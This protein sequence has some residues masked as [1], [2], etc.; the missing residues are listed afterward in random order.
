MPTFEKHRASQR[1]TTVYCLLKL[2]YISEKSHRI[3]ISSYGPNYHWTPD[4]NQSDASFSHV[5]YWGNVGWAWFWVET[6][7]SVKSE[8]IPP[9][10]DY[11]RVDCE[12]PRI[13]AG[14]DPELYPRGRL[15]R[16]P[17]STPPS[18][19]LPPFIVIIWSVF[20][21]QNL[22]P[23]LSEYTPFSTTICDPPRIYPSLPEYT[24]FSTNVCATLP[25][26]NH[27]PPPEYIP[28]STTIILCGPSRIYPSPESTPLFNQFMCATTTICDPP[29]IHPSPQ[30]IPLFQQLYATFPES[31]PPSQNIGLPPPLFNKCICATLPESTPPSKNIPPR[32]FN[33]YMRPS[34]NLPLL[35]R[36][37]HLFNKCMCD[38]HRIYPPSQ[39]IPPFSTTTCGCP[40]IYPSLPEYTPFST[41][42]ILCDPPRI[43]PSLPEST[44]LFNQFMC[45]T[46]PVCDVRFPCLWRRSLYPLSLQVGLDTPLHDNGKNDDYTTLYKC[47]RAKRLLDIR[48]TITPSFEL[49]QARTNDIELENKKQ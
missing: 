13:Y 33:N 45:A 37:Y 44:H 26:Q 39:N 20:G 10:P 21:S 5:T 12:R 23:S 34:H 43:Y 32:L 41:T 16:L 7:T 35:P 18:Q 15:W 25:S 19:D 48:R 9:P 8:K 22:P 29:R 3:I 4:S 30:N 28:F 47:C 49:L 1:C 46:L 38:P 14:V 27:P 24:P 17:E 6:N 36:I 42:I 11:T 40:R 2:A 31:T